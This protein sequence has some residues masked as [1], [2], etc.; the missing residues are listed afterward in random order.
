VRFKRWG[1][2][3]YDRATGRQTGRDT[4]RFWTSWGA[5]GYRQ[6]QINIRDKDYIFEVT[7]YEKGTTRTG[8]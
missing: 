6:R 3:E 5:W 1:V 7:H 4:P 8:A 2:V